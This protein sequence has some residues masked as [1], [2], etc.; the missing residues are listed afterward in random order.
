MTNRVSF[1]ASALGV[2]ALLLSPA[3]PVAAQT[4]TPPAKKYQPPRMPDGH[5]DLQGTYDL[6]T[7]TPVERP[8]GAKAAYTREEAAK[9]EAR[10][11]AQKEEGDAPISPNRKAPPKGNGD[12]GLPLEYHL[13][14]GGTG[15]YNYGWLDPGSAYNMVNG[16]IRSSIVVDPPNGRIP[17]TPAAAQLRMSAFR[18][19]LNASQGE[20]N[21]PGL[22]K[23]PTAYDGPERRPLSEQCI[24]GFGSTTG[25]PA[26]PDYF[27]DNLHQIVQTPTSVMILSEMIHDARII[28]MN[29][30]HLPSDIRQWMGDSV[31][32]WEGDTLVVDTT[33]FNDKTRFEGATENVHVVERF[34]RVDD[35]TLLYRFTVDDPATFSKPWTGEYSWPATKGQIYEYACHEGNYALGDILRGARQRDSMAAKAVK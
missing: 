27:Y 11:A 34:T 31:G 20:N 19:L 32:H 29:A 9:L 10:V 12:E 30:Q 8:A 1:L 35:H 21:D 2:V 22:E 28:R 7:L 4:A 16:E 6:A 15:G 33:N 5:P 25:P 14:A 23:D 26:L 3:I 13:A 24:L 18:A 17:F